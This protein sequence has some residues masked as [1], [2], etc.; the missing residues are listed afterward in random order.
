MTLYLKKTRDI[1]FIMD[2]KKF[3]VV[4]EG[5]HVKFNVVIENQVSMNTKLSSIQEKLDQTN[6][7]VAENS[8]MIWSLLDN[9]KDVHSKLDDHDLR[10][11]VA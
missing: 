7:K 1:I 5:L 10:L 9:M 4:L 3:T 2:D 11:A 6:E 8:F